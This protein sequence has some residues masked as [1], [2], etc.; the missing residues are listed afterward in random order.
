VPGAGEQAEGV[1]RE[2][3]QAADRDSALA[4]DLEQW[5]K[6]AGGALA[7]QTVVTNSISG[8]VVGGSVTQTGI[9]TT[10]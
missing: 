5:L 4:Q 3:L 10:Q 8:V 1:A 9:S 2:L 7:N 6:D